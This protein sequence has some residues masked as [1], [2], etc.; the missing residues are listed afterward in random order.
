MNGGWIAA[1][2]VQFDR[3][4]LLGQ[5]KGLVSAEWNVGGWQ[6]E[7]L[8]SYSA[9]ANN[10]LRGYPTYSGRALIGS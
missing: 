10:A 8:H 1:E 6:R 4:S 3:K 5:M 9:S 7:A 2:P